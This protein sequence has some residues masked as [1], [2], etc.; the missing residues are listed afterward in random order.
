M[1]ASQP[2]RSTDDRDVSVGGVINEAFRIYGENAAPLLGSAAVIFLI[3][4][5]IRGFLFDAG[6]VFLGLLAAI[7]LVAAQTLYVGFVVKLVD[8][9]RDGRRDFSVG[10]LFSSAA[11]KILPLIV[12]GIIVGIIVGVGF[13]LLIIPGLFLLTYLFVAAP[14][15]VV[16]DEGPFGAL[17][18]SWSLVSGNGL[19]VFGVVVVTVLIVIGISIV[20]S[21]I[22]AALGTAGAVILSVLASIVLAPIWALVVSVVFFNLGGGSAASGGAGGS[23]IEGGSASVG[24]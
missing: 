23:S 13:L 3:A 19:S 22:G 11:G 17:G 6:G 2:S 1:E 14:A 21:A 15:V 24:Y 7:V 20:A 10:E 16:E 5:L 8:D 9:V 4:G 12:V 18:R